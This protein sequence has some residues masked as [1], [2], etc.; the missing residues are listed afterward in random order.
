MSVQHKKYIVVGRLIK[1]HL[2]IFS[3]D[4]SRL[5]TQ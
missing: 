3:Y 2:F 4:D 5:I 1:M